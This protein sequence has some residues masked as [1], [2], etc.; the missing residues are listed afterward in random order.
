MFLLKTKKKFVANLKA[1]ELIKARDSE[2]LMAFITKPE[3]E[4]RNLQ[5][6][7]LK[8]KTFSQNIAN[9]SSDEGNPSYKI[10]AEYI[11]TVFRDYI[12]PLTKDWE[13]TLFLLLKGKGKVNHAES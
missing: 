4:A 11:G 9:D 1:E 7:I 13:S 5:R 12:M 2:G 6:V 10:N 8:A 3:V